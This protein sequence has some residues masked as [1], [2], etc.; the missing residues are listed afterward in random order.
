MATLPDFPAVY[1][2]LEKSPE[3]I[4]RSPQIKLLSSDVRAIVGVAGTSSIITHI[5]QHAIR[6]IAKHIA[7]HDWTV[8]NYDE[9]VIFLRE[10][11]TSTS[12]SPKT[13][14]SNV[15]GRN[16]GAGKPATKPKG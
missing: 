15:T 5:C 12:T 8:A 7:T 2:G 1:P 14:P 11:S 13:S 10:R 6:D 16:K 9:F 3:L 4:F